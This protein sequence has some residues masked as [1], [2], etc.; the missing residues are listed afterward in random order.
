MNQL[1]D[2]AGKAPLSGR[3]ATINLGE[4]LRDGRRYLAG[5]GLEEASLEAEVLLRHWLGVS[6]AFLF[7]HLDD[8]LP[9]AGP[10]KGRLSGEPE[11]S[12]QALLDR[13]AAREPLAYITG[14]KEFFG[15]ELHVDR[16]VLIPRPETET[17][18]GECLRLLQGRGNLA[19][20]IADVGTGSGAIA[21]ALASRLPH[22]RI[23]AIDSSAEAL[24]VAGL[25]CERHGV[26]ERVALLHGDLLEPLPEPA[27]IIVSNPPYIP[28]DVIGTL[29]P[30]VS[31]YEP[32][33]ALD[34]GPDGL[35]VVRR[36]LEQVGGAG[37]NPRDCDGEGLIG[38][39]VLRPGGWILLE[40]GW[41]QGTE[42]MR[43][44]AEAIQG[45][46]CRVVRDLAGRDRVL[47]VEIGG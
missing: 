43:I 27:D 28:S 26:D 39:P 24:E 21:V 17:L 9:A 20:I 47:V 16:R 6:R 2:R 46:S 34:G 36:L 44:A 12:Y 11:T 22:S 33:A 41:D 40:I 15:L 30:E 14:T 19:P 37:S 45:A 7:S 23:Y 38:R 1:M 25:N 4:A 18:V 5:L 29:A 35:D 42:A 8:P 31:V 3:N 13:R 32:R 10:V